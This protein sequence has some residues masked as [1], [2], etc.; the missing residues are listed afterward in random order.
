MSELIHERLSLP[1]VTNM[2]NSQPDNRE[3]WIT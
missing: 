1:F 2:D 3:K